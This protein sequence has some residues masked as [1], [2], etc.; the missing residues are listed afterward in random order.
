MN[1]KEEQKEGK[2]WLGNRFQV[3]LKLYGIIARDGKGPV[4]RGASGTS[5]AP[6]PPASP[7]RCHLPPRHLPQMSAGSCRASDSG[8]YTEQEDVIT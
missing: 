7:H 8:P 2:L 5:R 3:A 6:A 4:S 1:A